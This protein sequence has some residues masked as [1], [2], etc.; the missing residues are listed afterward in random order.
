MADVYRHHFVLRKDF[1]KQIDR[2]DREN[3]GHLG[4]SFFTQ[5]G[6]ATGPAAKNWNTIHA[7]AHWSRGAGRVERRRPHIS[8]TSSLWCRAIE[9]L[10]LNRFANWE[11]R[12]LACRVQAV[13]RWEVQQPLVSFER[14]YVA[15]AVLTRPRL[16]SCPAIKRRAHASARS[17]LDPPMT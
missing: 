12:C 14:V 13:P 11:K 10:D 16:D 1:S 8:T 4:N 2:Q 17:L 15:D 9:A 6:A 5:P 3:E 7:P